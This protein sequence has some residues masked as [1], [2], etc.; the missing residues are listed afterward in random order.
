M[1]KGKPTSKRPVENEDSH[2]S[3]LPSAKRHMA[4]RPIMKSAATS[5]DKGLLAQPRIWPPSKGLVTPPQ[6]P[7]VIDLCVELAPKLRLRPTNGFP[8][9]DDGDVYIDLGVI[10]RLAYQL[11][12]NILS[13]VSPWFDETLKHHVQEVDDRFAANYTKSTGIRARYELSYNSDLDI[14]VLGRTTMIKVKA[15]E[16]TSVTTTKVTSITNRPISESTAENLPANS[17][18]LSSNNP[19]NIQIEAKQPNPNSPPTSILPESTKIAPIDIAATSESTGARFARTHH[20]DNTS[21]LMPGQSTIKLEEPHI[22]KEEEEEEEVTPHLELS[23]NKENFV[24]TQENLKHTE[25]NQV[26]SIESRIAGK[27]TSAIAQE[28]YHTA[29][30]RENAIAEDTKFA[31]QENL[32]IPPTTELME[33]YKGL[34]RTYCGQTP[35]IDN[36]DINIALRQT[37]AIIRVA[38]LYGSIPTVRPYL[39]NCLMQFGRDIYKAILQDPPRWLLISLYLECA[40]IFKEAAVHIIGNLGHWPWPTFRLQDLPDDLSS[41]LKMKID[42]LKRLIADVERT[43]F[44]TSINVEGEEVH[45]APTDKRTINTWYVT[46][47]WKQWFIRSV[48]QDEVPQPAGRADGAKYRAIAKG[49]DAYLPLDTVTH[50]IKAFREPSRL[51]QLDKLGIEEDLKIIKVFAQKQVQVLCINRSML[52]VEEAGIEHL[53]CATV[54][55]VDI[56]WVQQGGSQ[57]ED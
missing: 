13:R 57:V 48:T 44:M 40:P 24:F 14:F 50:H 6:E 34:F 16:E 29:G 42:G 53:T 41:F 56:S 28:H 21:L 1:E 26:T 25:E 37:E 36:K 51:T 3:S 19:P 5:V 31:N 17:Q 43:L 32:A 4:A 8:R 11:H 15:I 18:Q 55:D 7:E 23:T 27:L 22:K 52:S 10:G 9:F 49:G 38:E 35:S 54:D 30:S 47:L 12:S 45:L 46:Q 39:G 2:L 20:D 33:A